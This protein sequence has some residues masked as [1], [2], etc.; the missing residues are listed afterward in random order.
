[1]QI[2]YF[3]FWIF[4]FVF[5]GVLHSQTISEVNK[6]LDSLRTKWED[7]LNKIEFLKESL[8]ATGLQIEKYEQIK[9]QLESEKKISETKIKA[10][11]VPEGGILRDAP[12]TVSNNMGA[13]TPKDIIYVLGYSGNLFFKVQSGK[14]TGYLIYS[15]IAENEEVDKMLEEITQNENKPGPMK[16]DTTDPKY[17]RLAK[18][19]KREIAGKLMNKQIWNGMSQGMV[20]ESLGKPLNKITKKSDIGISE[21]WDYPDKVLFL[22]NGELKK[23]IK[24]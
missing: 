1:M 17:I 13:I 7:K 22:E 21:Q 18:I 19:Y 6:K 24:R 9:K 15:S 14:Q 20:L 2:K 3:F 8:K 4:L 10:R 11:V 5:T 16:T 12:N 23:W